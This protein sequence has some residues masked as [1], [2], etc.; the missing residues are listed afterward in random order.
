MIIKF[1]IKVYGYYSGESSNMDI[2]NN[3]NCFKTDDRPAATQKL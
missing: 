2:T 3:T 1:S